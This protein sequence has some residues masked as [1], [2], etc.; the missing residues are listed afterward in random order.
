MLVSLVSAPLLG[1]LLDRYGPRWVFPIAAL[2]SGGALMACSTLQTLGHFVVYYGVPE[3]A[4]TD[5]ARGR[6][7]GGIALV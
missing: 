2:L 3:C 5:S 1:W 7:S 6:G 4:R